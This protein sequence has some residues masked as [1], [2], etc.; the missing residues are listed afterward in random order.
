MVLGTSCSSA[1]RRLSVVDL[2]NL[3]CRTKVLNSKMKT[4]V[5]RPIRSTW[6][7]PTKMAVRYPKSCWRNQWNQWNQW[8]HWGTSAKQAIGRMKKPNVV[9]QPQPQPQEQPQPK[10]L[11]LRS[12]IH[13]QIYAS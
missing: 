5:L 13:Q 10:S 8:N 6:G 1:Q 4:L 11:R 2:K 12:T 9:P 3:V 7:V